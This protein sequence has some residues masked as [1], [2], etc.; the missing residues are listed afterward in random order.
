MKAFKDN[1]FTTLHRLLHWVIAFSMFILFLTGFLRMKWMN[2]KVIAA[3]IESKTSAE[4]I[5]LSN[6]TLKAITKTIQAPMW[7]WH[8]I[9]AYVI[10]IAFI[11]R[12][13]YGVKEGFYFPNPFS[14]KTSAKDKLQGL[15]YFLIY[16]LIFTSIITG[17]YLK[18]GNG[19][20]KS[21]MEPIHKWGIYWFPI[22]IIIHF[23]GVV[24]GELTNKN[25]ITS[26][27]INGK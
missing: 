4:N 7:Q 20:Y 14:Q 16:F 25:G 11:V 22:F 8:E 15:I 13:I 26:K 3:V 17:F 10:L 9:A 2:K 5:F 21:I 24:I 18:W 12:V 1:K 27:M 23:A 6:E 19:S